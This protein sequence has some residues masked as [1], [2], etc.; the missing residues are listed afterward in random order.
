MM[1]LCAMLWQVIWN[2]NIWKNMYLR[3]TYIHGTNKQM[4]YEIQ[5]KEK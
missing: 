1:T 2:E 5:L 3:P 4:L